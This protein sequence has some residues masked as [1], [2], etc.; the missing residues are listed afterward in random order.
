[1]SE[2]CTRCG[3]TFHDDLDCP[4]KYADDEPNV[5]VFPTPAPPPP[6]YDSTPSVPDTPSYESPAPDPSS[7]DSG[8]GDFG[9]GGGS[10]D[11]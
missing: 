2:A 5:T 8:G 4:R 7:F 9:G 10:S 11:F 6:Y 3:S 1:M